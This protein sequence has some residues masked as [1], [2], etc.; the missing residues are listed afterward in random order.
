MTQH[1]G[2]ES[3]PD[4]SLSSEAATRVD[5]P[6]RRW[7]RLRAARRLL[8][9]ELYYVVTLAAF[10]VLTFFAYYNAY[11][12]WDVRAARALQTFPLP[13]LFEF[14]RV[15]SIAGNNWKPYALT[16]LTA[17]LFFAFRRNSEAFGLILSAGGSGIVNRIFKALIHRPRPDTDL[18]ELFYGS[19]SYSFP[20]GHVT[21]YV[22]YFGF[23][24]FVAYAI[25]P[26][27]SR[28]RTAALVLCALPVLLIGF[29]R[30]MLRAHW[31]SDT[32][33]AYLLGGMW[34]SLSL[35]MYRRWKQRSSFHPGSAPVEG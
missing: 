32:L 25:L 16:A 8:R 3:G 2:G 17:L 30:V 33:G 26:R 10:A 7:Q 5:E 11:F 31:P 18:A 6:P 12:G 34:L 29:S 23:L 27:E 20:S 28:V 4:V 1:D 19:D 13:G 22:C 9:V 14:M 35:V 21:F 15:V 24:F